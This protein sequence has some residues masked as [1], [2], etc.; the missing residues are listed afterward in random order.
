MGNRKITFYQSEWIIQ[1]SG[2]YYHS[3][4]YNRFWDTTRWSRNVGIGNPIDIRPI[5]LADINHCI[6]KG[7]LAKAGTIPS[8]TS[9]RLENEKACREDG[10]C[11]WFH[12][13][14]N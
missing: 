6:K 13:S 3:E 1:I 14:V 4:A 2:K 7:W 12:D 5:S 8:W 10:G 11:T 9:Y